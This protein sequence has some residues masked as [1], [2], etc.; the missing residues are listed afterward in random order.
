MVWGEVFSSGVRDPVCGSGLPKI[1]SA[2]VSTRF[3]NIKL[4]ASILDQID[5]AS[6]V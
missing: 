5:R 4:R 3:V 1:R 2:G 6:V